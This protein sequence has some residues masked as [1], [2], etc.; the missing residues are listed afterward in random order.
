MTVTFTTTQNQIINLNNNMTSIDLGECEILLRNY[1]NLT[2]NETIYMKKI[3]RIQEGMKIPKIE[4]DIYCKLN[5]TNLIKLN[6]SVCQNTKISLSIPIE[7]KDSLEKLN[8]SSEYYNDICYTAT[9]ESGT[10]IILN[11]RKNEYINNTVCQDDCDFSDYNYTSKRAN[12]SC[13][14]KESSKSFADINIDTN[15]LLSNFKNIKNVANLN[16]LSC[17]KSLFTKEGLIKNVGFYI[18]IILIIIRIISLFIFYIKQ[19]ELLKKKIENINYAIHNLD[20]IKKEN[21]NKKQKK[22]ENNNIN[23]INN[24]DNKIRI[25]NNNNKKGLKK[26]FP[27]KQIKKENVN[28]KKGNKIRNKKVNKKGNKFL[29]KKTKKNNDNLLNHDNLT[30]NNNIINSNTIINNNILN[31]NQRNIRNNNN[32]FTNNYQAQN[33]KK[34][35]KVKRIMEYID[36]EINSFRY[37]LAL[38]YDKR[39]YCQYYISLIKTQHDLIFAFCYNK[40][41]NSRII[42]FDLFFIWIFNSLYSECFILQ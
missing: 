12:C 17:N 1:Y 40:D 24:D 31:I 35:L 27:K 23:I 3:D 5:H 41:Y 6:L 11:D 37:E 8:S 32:L 28:N 16:L 22:K 15:K 26:K 19:L 9:S 36:D 20:I 38:Q 10:D 14:F 25:N 2:N 4:Y 18:F 29:K 33:K 21:G 42:K 30:N 13:N 39:S 34:I 7:I